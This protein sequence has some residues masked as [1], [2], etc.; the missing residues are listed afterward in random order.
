MPAVPKPTHKKKRPKNNPQTT[1]DRRC[2]YPRCGKPYAEQHE[3]FFGPHRQK[4]IAYGLQKDLCAE[5]HRGPLGPHQCREYDLQLKREAQARFEA[6][7]GTREDF[8]RIFG[9]NYL[10]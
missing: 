6:E 7:M 9:K 10:D 2:T 3:V 5:H 8:M 4:S 1:A